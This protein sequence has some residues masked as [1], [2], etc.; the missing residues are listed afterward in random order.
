[1]AID[2][3]TFAYENTFKGV[4]KAPKG[5]MLI[6]DQEGGLRPY[7][8]LLAALGG[9]FY[10]TFVEIATKKRLTFDSAE[11]EITG[12]RST[13]AP[14]MLHDALIKLT[15]KNASDQAQFLK[16]GQLAEVNCSIH[17]T[18]SKVAKISLEMYFK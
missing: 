13:E 6:G 9:C 12:N 8:L 4:A 11:M 10:H 1:M 5:E 16:T 7:N 15:V 18:L 17:N 3:I 2:K 14:Y